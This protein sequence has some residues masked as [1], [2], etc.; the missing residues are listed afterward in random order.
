MNNTTQLESI[1][2]VVGMG[3]TELFLTERHAYTVVKVSRSGKRIW[4]R[5]DIALRVDTNGVAECQQYDFAPDFDAP[6]VEARLLKSGWRS[7]S[8]RFRFALRRFTLGTRQEY[9]NP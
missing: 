4:L 9:H 6:T 1:T 7:G 8:S 5:R 3:A 2:P